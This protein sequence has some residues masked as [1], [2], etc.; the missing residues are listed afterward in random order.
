ML[1]FDLKKNAKT[2][3]AQVHAGLSKPQWRYT[4]VEVDRLLEADPDLT[5]P[6][7]P[8]DVLAEVHSRVN[9]QLA[10]EGIPEVRYDVFSWRMARAIQYRT[11]RKETEHVLGKAVSD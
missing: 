9:S 5:W 11:A 3:E 1:P 8:D 4:T 7:I 10:K 6:S 2:R